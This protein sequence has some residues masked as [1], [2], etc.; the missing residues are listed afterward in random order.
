MSSTGLR[1]FFVLSSVQIWQRYGL[2]PV[3]DRRSNDG[4]ICSVVGTRLVYRGNTGTTQQNTRGPALP[5]EK[6]RLVLPNARL[7][8]TT[9]AALCAFPKCMVLLCKQEQQTEH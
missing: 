4:T 6:R 3:F 9:N 5:G 7:I 1:L 2:A 8:F